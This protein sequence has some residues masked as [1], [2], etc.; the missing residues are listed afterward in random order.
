MNA[1]ETGSR[2]GTNIILM[3][4]GRDATPPEHEDARVLFDNIFHS[5]TPQ[6]GTR[7]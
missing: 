7:R 1:P 2:L 4:R 5:I 3:V 6:P